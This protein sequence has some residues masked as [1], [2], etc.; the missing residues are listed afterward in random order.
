MDAG[1]VDAGVEQRL[2]ALGDHAERAAQVPLVDL[3]D[4]QQ[5]GEQPLQPVAVD[6]PGQQLALLLLAGQHV[7]HLQPLRV[8]VLEVGQLLE[9]HDVALR[10]V[11][12]DEHDVAAGSTS[13]TV[14]AMD[15]TGVMPLPAATRP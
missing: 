5:R 7:Q 13:S 9:E 14:A 2:P 8:A 11:A 3:V 6:P 4:G 1:R 12:V 10:A 15:S